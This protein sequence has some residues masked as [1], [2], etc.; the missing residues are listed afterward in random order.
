MNGLAASEQAKSLTAEITRQ[1]GTLLAN[2]DLTH[3]FK[4]DSKDEV[5]PTSSREARPSCLG[6]IIGLEK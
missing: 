3:E 4:S 6:C 1:D 2:G 5:G